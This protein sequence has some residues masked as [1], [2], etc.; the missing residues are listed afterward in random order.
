MPAV[1][2]D[3]YA[4]LCHVLCQVWRHHGGDL[5]DQA[6]VD[7]ARQLDQLRKGRDAGLHEVRHAAGR[8]LEFRDRFPADAGVAAAALDAALY[9]AAHGVE[10]PATEAEAEPAVVDLA[11]SIWIY[12]AEFGRIEE[13]MVWAGRHSRLI[14]VQDPLEDPLQALCGVGCSA[15]PA[16][17]ETPKEVC[18]RCRKAL[19]V[20]PV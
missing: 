16:S 4:S 3:H 12:P 7:K 5:M 13:T 18:I 8:L 1:R 17:I 14:H 9:K 15:A 2:R 19:R 11:S 20:A 6:T 10:K